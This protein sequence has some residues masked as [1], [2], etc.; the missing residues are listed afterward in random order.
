MSRE[1]QGWRALKLVRDAGGSCVR[2]YLTG[3]GIWSETIDDLVNGG[4]L[5]ELSRAEIKITKRGRE[6]LR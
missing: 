3:M 1:S 2:P 6:S 5:Q 4:F